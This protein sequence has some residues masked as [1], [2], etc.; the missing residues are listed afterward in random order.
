M[1]EEPPWDH[2]SDQQ[3]PP[4][5]QEVVP[6]VYPEYPEYSE[7]LVAFLNSLQKSL[8]P[9]QCFTEPPS[10]ISIQCLHLRCSRQIW[11]QCSAEAKKPK[12]PDPDELRN[13]WLAY[14]GLQGWTLQG[15]LMQ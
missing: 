9:M 15:T 11:L 3:G 13:V 2:G 8:N 6:E 12:S 4:P 10:S 14:P 5:W 1:G 7:Y